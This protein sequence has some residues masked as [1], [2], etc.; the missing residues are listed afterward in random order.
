MKTKNLWQAL[1][2]LLQQME[3]EGIAVVPDHQG[4]HSANSDGGVIWDSTDMEWVVYEN[5]QS[6]LVDELL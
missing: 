3:D 6:H 1:R 2:A 4:L 5:V